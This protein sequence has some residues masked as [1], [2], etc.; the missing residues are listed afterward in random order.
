MN[1][2][3]LGGDFKGLNEGGKNP[4]Y[5]I[6]A[7]QLHEATGLKVDKVNKHIYLTDLG[8]SVYRC[9]MDGKEKKLVYDETASFTGIAL[10]HI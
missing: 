4:E 3:H 1:S 8:G 9:N 2:V 6:M 7:R 10:A 5:K